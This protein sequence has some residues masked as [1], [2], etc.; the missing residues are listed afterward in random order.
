M[1]QLGH[2]IHVAVVVFSL[3]IWWEV[4][5]RPEY[6]PRPRILLLSVIV[7]ALAGVPAYV[8]QFPDVAATESGLFFVVTWT[9]FLYYLALTLLEYSVHT[10][11]IRDSFLIEDFRTK[12]R[13]A[14]GYALPMIFAVIA[15]TFAFGLEVG[16]I[17]FLGTLATLSRIL[18]LVGIITAAGYA[19][20]DLF[21]FQAG[22]LRTRRYPFIVYLAAGILFFLSSLLFLDAPDLR[23][24]VILSV[25]FAYRLYGE[26]FSR[27]LRNMDGLLE[28]RQQEADVRNRLVD[29]L[30]H[31]PV[32]QD[33]LMVRNMVDETLEQSAQEIITPQHRI[34]GAMMYRRVNDTL[35]VDSPE[36]ISGFCTPLYEIAHPR[37]QRRDNL[38]RLIQKDTYD[39]KELTGTVPTEGKPFGFRL[40]REAVNTGEISK[41]DTIPEAYRGI[42][43]LIAAVPVV[44]QGQIRGV[45]V[46][47]KD[48]FHDL[49]PQERKR[50]QQFAEHLNTVF[51]IMAGKGAQEERNRLKGELDIAQ[52]IQTSIV[53]QEI[54]LDG[55]D[56]GSIMTTASEV[57]GDAYDFIP[58]RDGNYFAIGDVAGHGLP[59]GI[60]ALI[61]IAATHGAVE[62]A[63]A[64]ERE[65]PVATLYNAVN[66]VLCSINRDRIGSDK[67]MT[68]NYLMHRNGSFAHAG[69]HEIALVYRASEG[70]VQQLTDT[71]NKTAFMGVSDFI[72][73]TP[74]VGEVSLA[75]GD[76]LLLYTDG[77]IEARNDE[78][79][80]FGLDRL[81]TSLEQ[82]ASL[83][84]DE[85]VRAIEQDVREF[86]EGGDLKRHGGRFA[87]DVTL[88]AIKKQSSGAADSSEEA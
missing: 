34:T 54:H 86:A 85:L 28:R 81:G 67:F 17:A 15:S 78:G 8:W 33:H 66:R 60:M 56:I 53:P 58:T 5:G 25:L 38:A 75:P 40:M 12:V 9:L 31:N 57:G 36:L 71:V 45:I 27:R 88:V 30:I 84:G 82:H 65:I 74:S 2:I 35:M 72:D 62:A 1:G 20:L 10:Q 21:S 19:A 42:H 64:F 87:D 41:L 48:E 70:K 32:E 16:G 69:T 46:V 55:Y 24:T 44:D 37:R 6:G 11:R 4:K 29:R 43:N 26:Y 3:P 50:L 77:T 23:L 52:Q 51:S 80:Q 83:T 63:K 39:M 79:E 59:S 49:F 68:G 13:R 47:F 76:V 61:H 73:A 14:V 18:L 7:F 22:V